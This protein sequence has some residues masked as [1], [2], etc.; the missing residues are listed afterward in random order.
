MRDPRTF[1]VMHN[2]RPLQFVTESAGGHR[3][4][5]M[6]L[7][8]HH[9]NGAPR[10][11][12]RYSLQLQTD[13]N[14]YLLRLKII[15]AT[16]LAKKDI[17]GA[18]DPY[19]RVE[20]QKLDSDV[21]LETFLTKTKKK[22]LNPVWN[23]EFVFRVNPREHKLLIQVFDENR[24][25]RD[26]FLGMVE[27]ALGAVPTESAAAARPPPLKYP[28]RPRSAR[29][30][31]R[32]HIEVYAALVGRVGEPGVAA[33]AER[34]DDWEL[35]HAAPAAGEVHSVRTVPSAIG[36]DWELID[37]SDLTVVGDPLPPGWEERQDGNGRTYYVNHIERS[38]QWERPTFTRNQSVESQAERMETAVTEFQ[39][40]FHISADEEHSSPASSQHQEELSNRSGAT[41][42]TE[43]TPYSTP[44][45]SPK[46]ATEGA[47]R[48][49]GESDNVAST[50]LSE[51]HCDSNLRDNCE[52][53]DVVCANEGAARL[54]DIAENNETDD[55]QAEDASQEVEAVQ[56]ADAEQSND[57]DA[58]GESQT[59]REA[60]TSAEQNEMATENEHSENAEEFAEESLT[61]DENHFSTPTGGASPTSSRR[62][63]A[64][65]GSED[66]TDGSTESTRSSSASSTQSQNL[67]NADGLPPGWTMQKAPNGR[68]FFID[69]N[70]KTTTWI[71]PRTGCASSLPSA[72]A[73]TA[74]AEADELGALPEG[75][76]ERVHTDGRIFFIDHNTRTT[77][78]EDPRLSNPQIAGPAVPYSRDYKRKYEYLKSQLRKPSN[79][80]NKFE[81]KVRR[82]SILEDS[83]RIITS[84]NRIELLKTKLWVEFESEVGL[85]YGG[86]AREWFFLLSKEMFNPYYGLFEY[87][88]M[89]N[90]TLQ[91]NPNSGVCNEEHLS[92]FK[93]I[94][95]VAGMAVYHGK[96]LDAFFIR[97]F[98]KMML[99]KPIELQD[100]ESVDLEYYN[101]LIYIKEN[102]PSE[103]YLT[104][105]VDEEQFGKT[106]QRD[107]KPG[108]ANIPVDEEN[109][110]EYI[111]LV[112]QWRFVSRVQEQMSS[113]LEGFGAL[114]PLNLLKIFDEHELELLLCGIQHIDVR[115][116]R[117]NTLYKGD[118]H[119]NHI[120]VQWFWRVVLSF[121]NEMRSRLLQF[122]TGTSRVPMNGF[123]EL[124]GSNGPQLFTIERWG[125]PDN[126]PRAHTCFN[127]IDLPP[128]ESYQQLREK[129]VK[130]IEGSQGF[131]GVD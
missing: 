27:L 48:N 46:L 62:R 93:F 7:S 13:E 82:N 19:V 74:G 78:W 20:L 127:R 97:P 110:D 18:S 67:P 96:L 37:A 128:Y 131:A 14:S 55:A 31:V 120:V 125:S 54:Q 34:G 121:S 40:R 117:A 119:A 86:L 6:S 51:T 45:R 57:N 8:T 52:E 47:E 94:G 59:E 24:L 22:T 124:Y 42:S 16:S 41:N 5:S 81:I 71:D 112:I 115:D 36:C 123:K 102:D 25:T 43:P 69:H 108:G 64:S 76:E 95:R 1:A 32:G 17:F 87:S 3:N 49:D 83:Y 100:M 103:L 113:F 44:V 88:A 68:I 58:N 109:K 107:L 98:Y 60:E 65:S 23:Q 101:S 66:E 99:S 29:S 70:Q 85:D 79:V 130:A 33:A 21:T 10:P 89:D 116:W 11:E 84:V 56:A 73:A 118:Y 30:R 26:D 39:R 63:S 28:L 122:V 80:P 50:S 77:Q 53:D 114:V 2:V 90:Y 4:R 106:I 111:K 91:I 15:G 92:Y 12:P 35:V 104:F 72:A 126:Y 75:W 129:L 9:H 38:T 105:S 61:F